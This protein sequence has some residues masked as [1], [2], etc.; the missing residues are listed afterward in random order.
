MCRYFCHS[1]RLSGYELGCHQPMHRHF[2]V[3]ESYKSVMP[4][5]RSSDVFSYPRDVLHALPKKRP[6]SYPPVMIIKRQNTSKTPAFLPCQRKIPQHSPLSLSSGACNACLPGVLSRG[7]N[8]SLYYPLQQLRITHHHSLHQGL[9]RC[10]HSA[11]KEVCGSFD[12]VPTLRDTAIP[13]VSH[14]HR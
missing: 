14:V 12:Q 10:E 13:A 5:K 4:L 6:P 11:P 8:S 1:W 3:N 9:C 2:P 7:L